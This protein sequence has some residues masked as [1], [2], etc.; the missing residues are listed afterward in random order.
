[1]EFDGVGWVKEYRS[2]FTH[3][4]CK[5]PVAAL[6]FKLLVSGAAHVRRIDRSFS[7]PYE[8]DRGQLVT[9][10]AEICGY[11]PFTVKQVRSAL[12]HLESEAMITCRDL[13]RDGFNFSL[14]TIV[15]Y[16]IYQSAHGEEGERNMNG[17][18]K[19]Q[20]IGQTVGQTENT[21]KG[22]RE[23]SRNRLS[24]KG[25]DDIRKSA[26]A[27]HSQE[28][29]QTVGQTV[30]QSHINKDEEVKNINS[31]YPLLKKGGRCSSNSSGLLGSDRERYEMVLAMWREER[32]GA[33]LDYQED[34]PTTRGAATLARDYLNMARL[35][36]EQ[37]REGMRELVRLVKTDPKCRRYTLNTLAKT[38]STYCPAPAIE[39]SNQRKVRWTLEC[40]VCGACRAT[41][42][43]PAGTACPEPQPCGVEHCQ[44]MLRVLSQY[45]LDS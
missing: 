6:V 38:P 29:G 11:L 8:I 24:G 35:T 7:R 13:R 31:P 14:V 40:D 18:K 42:Y 12:L 1:M 23:E 10:V 45:I 41:H 3:P 37:L 43:M 27:N 16:G 30:G 19:G 21:K 44:G 32:Y 9:S 20:T 4:I 33:G 2:F 39:A 36:V 15:N 17:S 26:G 5:R 28:D 22:K 25:K 34:S